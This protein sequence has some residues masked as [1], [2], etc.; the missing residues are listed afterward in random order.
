MHETKDIYFLLKKKRDGPRQGNFHYRLFELNK[1]I[2][3]YIYQ[4]NFYLTGIKIFHCCSMQH[5]I[6]IK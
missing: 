6:Q 1:S 2:L 3:Y 5:T 4:L